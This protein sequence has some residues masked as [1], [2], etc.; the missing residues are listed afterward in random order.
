M[1]KMEVVEVCPECGTKAVCLVD[2]DECC[3]DAVFL[4]PEKTTE[5]KIQSF[6]DSVKGDCDYIENIK[7]RLPEEWSFFERKGTVVY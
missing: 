2:I 7:A 5:E 1:S 3:T 6:I 4:V